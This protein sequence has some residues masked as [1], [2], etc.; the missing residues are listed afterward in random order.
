MAA[1]GRVFTG[2][3]ARLLVNGAPVGYARNCNGGESID[4]EEV[5]VLDNIEV[6]EHVP[7]K[8]R[9][10]FSA[11]FVRLVGETAKTLGHFPRLGGNPQEHLKNILTSGA[12]T[13]A[14]ED[15]QTNAIIC[16]LEQAKASSNNFSVDAVGI[17]ARDMEFVAIR[18]RDESE[19]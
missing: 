4:Y 12:L 5:N 14:V 3:R 15:N 6:E 13:V 9:V 11:G 2:A 10:R 19:V 17:V 18:M 16:T 7:T 8:Y 1:K